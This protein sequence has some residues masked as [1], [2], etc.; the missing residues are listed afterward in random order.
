MQLPLPP[1]TVAISMSNFKT[2]S[3]DNNIYSY[4]SKVAL[5]KNLQF[6]SYFP[7]LSSLLLCICYINAAWLQS[8]TCNYSWDINIYYKNIINYQPFIIYNYIILLVT[9]LYIKS[10]F[11]Y[12]HTYVY[13]I[14][15]SRTM[16][17]CLSVC[18][19]RSR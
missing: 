5:N 16:S 9:K 18:N 6:G 8:S 17:V 10:A 19:E 11:T 14:I 1:S 3:G 2:I 15:Q 7:P 4:A 13:S 12:R